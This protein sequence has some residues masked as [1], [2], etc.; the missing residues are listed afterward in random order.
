MDRL[1]RDSL[2]RT[3]AWAFL[4]RMFGPG[5]TTSHCCVD[6]AMKSPPMLSIPGFRGLLFYR[7]GRH[8]AQSGSLSINDAPFKYSMIHCTKKMISLRKATAFVLFRSGGMR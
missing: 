2:D 7:G 6:Q 1:E 5:G 3:S 4:G 8:Y